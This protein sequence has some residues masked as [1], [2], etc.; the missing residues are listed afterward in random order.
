MGRGQWPVTGTI[1]NVSK[2]TARAKWPCINDHTCMCAQ[3]LQD[4]LP[5]SV[6]PR[7]QASVLN[8]I[9]HTTHVLHELIAGNVAYPER[10]LYCM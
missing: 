6:D 4:C 3:A 2:H 10:F 1:A 9:L 5:N 8:Y 7:N